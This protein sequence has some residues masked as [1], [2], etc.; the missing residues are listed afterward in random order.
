MFCRHVF[1]NISGRFRGI[2]P[3][4]GNFAGPRSR[5]TSEALTYR[6]T[7]FI[8]VVSF[9][10]CLSASCGAR[11]TSLVETYAGEEI[12]ELREELCLDRLVSCWSR[13]KHQRP[14]IQVC[15]FPFFRASTNMKITVCWEAL[16]STEYLTIGW[17]ENLH[18]DWVFF[19]IRKYEKVLLNAWGSMSIP[20]MWTMGTWQHSNVLTDC[21]VFY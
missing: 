4:M 14:G 6:N 9:L 7:V 8:V 15:S 3:F 12:N 20:G 16:Y 10:H 2:L 18:L 19:C 1:G 5:E 13:I 21:Y 11:P 17:L